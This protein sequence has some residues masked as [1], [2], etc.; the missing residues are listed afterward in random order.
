VVE[1]TEDYYVYGTKTKIQSGATIDK[2]SVKAAQEKNT[3]KFSGG[4]F[5]LDI[6]PA[7]IAGM[8]P[9][10]SAGQYRVNNIQADGI[11]F[12]L[13][14]DVVFTGGKID[15]APLNIASVPLGHYATFT[16]YEKVTVYLHQSIPGMVVTDVSSRPITVTFGGGT[17]EITLLYQPASGLFAQV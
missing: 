12:G 9:Q 13:A 3:Y 2:L 17:D 6:N 16:P 4:H 11:L 8:P 7:D 14:Q 15:A 1:W 5:G 10:L